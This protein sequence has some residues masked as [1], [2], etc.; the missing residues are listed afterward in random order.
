MITDVNSSS[1]E[2][3][4]HWLLQPAA[5]AYKGILH[6][7]AY[8]ESEKAVEFSLVS[9]SCFIHQVREPIAS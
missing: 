4:T 8:C 7:A 5:I 2:E 1:I 9:G 3:T 6:I